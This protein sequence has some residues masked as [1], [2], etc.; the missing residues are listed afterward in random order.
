M[1]NAFII[2]EALP[3]DAENILE[4]I[5]QVGGESDNLTFGEN[6]YPMTLAEEQQ[7]LEEMHNSQRS[8]VMIGQVGN[9]VAAVA[10]LKGYD[11]KRM[12]LAHRAELG[13]SV[14]QKYWRRGIASEIID[15]LIAFARK[16][17][18]TVI[19]LDVRCDNY[20]AIEL[21]K[22]KGFEKIGTFKRFMR[23][24]GQ[25]CDAFLMNLYL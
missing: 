9:E 8:I 17:S 21:Y 13:V 12:R 25:Y 24:K 16:S 14:K 1:S 3:E 4:Y 19:E 18:I 10:S 11:L 20:G 22:N 15:C 2:R 5:N 7:Y 23:I 6:E